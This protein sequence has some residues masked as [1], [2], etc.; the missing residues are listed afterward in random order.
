MDKESGST[1]KLGMFVA[2]G[3]LLFIMAIY[4]IRLKLSYGIF[5]LGV[6][7]ILTATPT[8]VWSTMKIIRQTQAIIISSSILPNKKIRPMSIIFR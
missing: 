4:F 2:I 7:L 6:T 1:W 3:L 8:K 5:M